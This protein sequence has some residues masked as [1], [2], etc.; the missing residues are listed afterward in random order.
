MLAHMFYLD[1]RAHKSSYLSIAKCHLKGWSAS[2]WNISGITDSNRAQYLSTLDYCSLHPLNGEYSAWIDD[3]LTIKHILSGTKAGG[4]MPNYYYLIL[5]QGRIIP[6]M[7]APAQY[8]DNPIQGI[9]NILKMGGVIALKQIKGSLGEGFYKGEYRSGTFYMNAQAYSET[10]FTQVVR[11]L[12]GYLVTEFLRPHPDIAK[13][14]NQTVGCLRYVV[15]RRLDGSVM[16]IY[17]FMR[18]G[19]KQSK[20]V[21][22]YNAGGVLMV[23]NDGCYDGGNILD[24]GSNK[25]ITI[26]KHP[27]NDIPLQGKIPLWDEV[28]KAAHIIA[29]VLPELSYMGIDFC[30]THDNQVKVI[31]INSLTSLDCMQTDKS[32]LAIPGGAFFSERLANKRK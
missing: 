31:E 6:L 32:I 30:L 18:L 21:E 20:F 12:K 10:E 28:V 14:C 1:Y 25:N 15:G 19:T 8:V 23:V 5:S 17:S 9:V 7:D 2:D 3:K 29:D 24:F 27:D 11:L 16:D 4:Y 26:Q 22:N 13:F